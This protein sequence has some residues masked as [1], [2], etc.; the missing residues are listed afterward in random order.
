M[1]SSAAVLLY[2][3]TR[4]SWPPDPGSG[5][6]PQKLGCQ[7]CKRFF[8]SSLRQGRWSARMWRLLVSLPLVG[9]VVGS[10]M[11]GPLGH[12][13]ED[14]R[15]GAVTSVLGLFSSCLSAVRVV[16]NPRRNLPLCVTGSTSW[17]RLGRLA[18]RAG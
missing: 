6:Q 10:L 16:W 15:M 12:S 14:K 2:L 9:I 4:P 13:R 17:T 7:M 5:W 18:T 8:V 11:C 1:A 3:F